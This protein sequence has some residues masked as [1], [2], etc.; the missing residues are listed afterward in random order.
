[1]SSTKSVNMKSD[2]ELSSGEIA[3]IDAE[4]AFMWKDCPDFD[5]ADVVKDRVMLAHGEL[6]LVL[7]RHDKEYYLVY[8]SKR[9]RL[10]YIW[11]IWLEVLIH[12]G[13]GAIHV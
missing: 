7:A 8:E 1:M 5:D 11:G 9:Q 13:A 10:G 3:F 2:P 4:N 6:V 12:V